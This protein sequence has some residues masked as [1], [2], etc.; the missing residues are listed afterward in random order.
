MRIYIVDIT[1]YTVHVYDEMHILYIILPKFFI[2]QA[3]R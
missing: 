1:V 2:I 3:L